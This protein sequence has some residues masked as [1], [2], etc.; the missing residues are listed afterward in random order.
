MG[1]H[2]K[3]VCIYMLYIMYIPYI[4]MNHFAVHLKLIQHCKSTIFQLKNGF[5][6]LRNRFQTK[7]Q[8]WQHTLV[9]CHLFLHS[10]MHLLS[11][12]G[13]ACHFLNPEFP[14]RDSTMRTHFYHEQVVIRWLT[15]HRTAFT[16]GVSHSAISIQSALQEDVFCGS[17]QL[18]DPTRKC[19]LYIRSHISFSAQRKNVL[20]SI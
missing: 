10:R 12:R 7:S 18:T 11:G 6:F 9:P 14:C 19:R 1:M 2:L 4:Y 5:I 13:V 15:E 20:L 8:R 3:N 16:T 17:C